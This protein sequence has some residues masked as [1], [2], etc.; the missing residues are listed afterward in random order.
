MFKLPLLVGIVGVTIALVVTIASPAASPPSASPTVRK[1]QTHM[2]KTAQQ[3]HAVALHRLRERDRA[4]S[5]AGEA[6]RYSRKLHRTIDRLVSANP[7]LIMPPVRAI[8][9]AEAA[10]L[11]VTGASWDCLAALISRENA[12]VPEA[13]NPQRWNGAGSGAYGLPQALPGSKMESAG[14]DWF[15]NPATQVRWMVAYTER[16]GGPCGADAFQRAHHSY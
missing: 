12:N 2:G 8:A 7:S 5:K 6:I 13:W 16:Y 15:W 11:G 3:W 1:V 10:R 14:S 4:R 9:R